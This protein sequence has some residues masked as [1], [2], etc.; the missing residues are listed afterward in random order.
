[1]YKDGFPPARQ[2]GDGR[3][4]RGPLAEQYGITRQEQDEYAVETHTAAKSRPKTQESSDG[5]EAS[6]LSDSRGKTAR[7]ETDEHARDGATMEGMAKLPPVFKKGGSVHAGNFERHHRRRFRCRRRFR[8]LC[9]L[10]AQAAGQFPGLGYS[11][12]RAAG[13]GDRSRPRRGASEKWISFWLRPRGAQRGLRRAGPRLR[14]RPQVRRL[15]PQRRRH[16][17]DSPI[18]ATIVGTPPTKKRQASA[19]WRRRS[20]ADGGSLSRRRSRRTA[21][22]LAEMELTAPARASPSLLVTNFAGPR[23]RPGGDGLMEDPRRVLSAKE[24]LQCRRGRRAASS[25]H[26]RSHDPPDSMS[27]PPRVARPAGPWSCARTA[28]ASAGRQ[29]CC[30]R[31]RS[32]AA[33]DG[34]TLGFPMLGVFP[35]IAC[36][37]LGRAVG[38]TRATPDPDRREFHGPRGR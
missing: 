20:A 26:L 6:D 32:V 35:P 2:Q 29:N 12:C 22:T 3:D 38:Q 30:S 1:M 8:R 11:R 16:R 13:H 21:M 33:E 18:G 17:T 4:R 23:R 14:P 37:L 15:P 28:P 24:G 34:A 36:A 10:G 7:F 31:T 19:G 25:P 5:T 9:E 27:V